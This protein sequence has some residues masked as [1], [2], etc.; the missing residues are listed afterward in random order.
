MAIFAPKRVEAS[1]AVA[2]SDDASTDQPGAARGGLSILDL[3]GLDLGI[4][5]DYAMS[6]PAYRRAVTLAMANLSSLKFS[7]IDSKG[8]RVTPAAFLRQP[9]PHRTLNSL[10]AKTV[11]D[12][13]HYGVAYWWNENY[14]SANGWRYSGTAAPKHASV[15]YVPVEDVTVIRTKPYDPAPPYSIVHMG[16]RYQVPAE[17]VIAFEAPTGRWLTDGSRTILTTRLLEDAVR[18]YAQTPQ[19][20]SIIKNNGPKK[21]PDQISAIIEAVETARRQHST[22]Y[23]GRDLEL[24]HNSFDATQIALSEARDAQTLEIARLTGI[25][26]IYLS[27]GVANNSHGYSNL[28]QQ[29]LDLLS[30]LAPFAEAISARLSF[31]DVTGEGS[32]VEFD[33][34]PFMRVDPELRATLYEKLIPLGV[35]TV[36]EC[37]AMESFAGFVPINTTPAS[38]ARPATPHDTPGMPPE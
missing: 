28:T 8:Q 24:D 18:M 11:A 6:V 22:A 21:T 19:P 14:L 10:L 38:N 33:F 34:G 36:E 20:L 5:R 26:S 2:P 3:E 12:L 30:A 29:R 7:Q 4:S 25:P 35:L 16:K 17:S 31:D 37:R 9:D 32:S 15:V 27:I 1:S 13:C 23:V